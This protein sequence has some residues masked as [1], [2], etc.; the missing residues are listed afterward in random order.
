MG[1][2]GVRVRATFRQ[3]RLYPTMAEPSAPFRPQPIAV[4]ILAVLAIVVCPRRAEAYRPFDG[5]DADTAELGSFEL[6]LGPVHYYRQ[7]PQNFLITPALVLNLGIF[8]DTELVIDVDPYVALGPLS[9]GVSRASLLDDDILLKHTFREGTLQGKTG[10]SIAA[11]GGLLTPEFNGI[12]GERGLS[13]VGGSLDVIT[14]YRFGFGAVHWNEWFEFTR[15]QHADLFTG[16]IVEGPH[17]WPVRPVAEFYFDKDF[18]GSQTGSGL[19]GAIW[20]VRESFALDVGLRGA[21]VG[22]EYAAEVRLGF[23]WAIPIWEP[24]EE[25]VSKTPTR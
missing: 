18:A 20:V 12:D 19:V 3:R 11:E 2:I 25:P 16:V 1:S 15:E 7:G 14:S 6:E 21:R 8:E 22:D 24:H 9:P 13:N 23:T 17:D 4:A 10:V 5:T